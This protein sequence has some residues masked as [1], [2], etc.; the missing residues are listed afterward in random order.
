M[1]PELPLDIDRVPGFLEAGEGAALYRHGCAAVALGP[2]VEIGSYCGRSTV[3]LGC[4]CRDSGG[5]LYAVDH[6]RGSE[7]HQ[8]G[9][10]FHDPTLLDP[11]TGTVDTFRRFRQTLAAAGLEPFVLP[12]VAGGVLFAAYFPGPAG[13][14]FIDGGH[15][16]AAALADYRAWAGKVAR[17]GVLAIHDIYPDPA[18]GGQA[19]AAVRRLAL[20]S[21]LFEEIDAAGSLRVLRRL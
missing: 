19:P 12:V 15:S 13:L 20:D 10:A 14:V 5:A 18:S 4:A 2:L 21:G 9:E 7:E 16:L 8:P 1:G 3:Y 11:G 6:H 17:G